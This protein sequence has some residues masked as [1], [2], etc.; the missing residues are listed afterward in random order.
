AMPATRAASAALFM[1]L[2]TLDSNEAR[3]RQRIV[4]HELRRRCEQICLLI[5]GQPSQEPTPVLT[6]PGSLYRIANPSPRTLRSL[7]IVVVVECS[8]RVETH[9]PIGQRLFAKGFMLPGACCR[10]GPDRESAT[11]FLADRG[12][13]PQRPP[14]SVIV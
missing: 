12:R 3:V 6:P 2:V 4:A 13:K 14:A 1:R 11:R 10:R 8:K 9:V 7:T 5:L